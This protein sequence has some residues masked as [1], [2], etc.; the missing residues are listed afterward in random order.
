MFLLLVDQSH[1]VNYNL[2]DD[3][4]YIKDEYRM[5]EDKLLGEVG[6][7]VTATHSDPNIITIAANAQIGF[8]LYQH[9][10]NFHKL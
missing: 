4:S 6:I 8:I 2:R 7:T 10:S 5:S 9:L 1:Y 3:W